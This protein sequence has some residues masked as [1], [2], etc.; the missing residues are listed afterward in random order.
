MSSNSYKIY[1]YSRVAADTA[2][3]LQ[4]IGLMYTGI[5]SNF[6]VITDYLTY[7]MKNPSTKSIGKIA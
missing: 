5:L 6:Q 3:I 7:F 4:L 1:C 2:L